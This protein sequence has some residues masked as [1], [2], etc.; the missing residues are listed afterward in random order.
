MAVPT[1]RLNVRVRGGFRRM[2]RR[3]LGLGSPKMLVISANVV[4]VAALVAAVALAPRSPQNHSPTSLALPSPP[5]PPDEL[6]SPGLLQCLPTP[7]PSLIPTTLPSL[8]PRPAPPPPARPTS[9]RPGYWPQ[10]GYDPGHSGYNPQEGWLNASNVGTLAHYWQGVGEGQGSPAV[11]DRKVFLAGAR[12][13][14]YADTSVCPPAGCARV[15]RG[16]VS[17]PNANN[18]FS[19]PAIAPGYAFLGSQQGNLYAYSE[20]GCGTP[21]RRPTWTSSHIGTAYRAPTV[22]DGMAFVSAGDVF[23]STQP[24]DRLD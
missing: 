1:L 3:L 23:N 24:D 8:L 11:A 22:A 16:F 17:D 5:S 9:S 15:W 4:A 6:C 19:A 13:W 21:E 7:I 20:N 2:A 14:V 10:S 18:G 12:L